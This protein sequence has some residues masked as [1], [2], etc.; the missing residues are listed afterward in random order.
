MPASLAQRAATAERRKKAIQLALAGVN[1]DGISE[2]LGYADRGSAHKDITRF[3][4]QNLKEGSANGEILR[5][6]NRL[7]LE[8][9]LVATW[10]NAATGDLKAVDTA[11][12]LIES[13][14]K[15]YNIGTTMRVEHITIDQVDAEIAALQERLA[16]NDRRLGNLPIEAT[17][18]T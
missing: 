6:L 9:L 15:M 8:R 16:E 14:N 1:W 11:R 17:P 7:R 10:A 4:Q 18:I 3:L 12:R 2:Q 5:E 13:M